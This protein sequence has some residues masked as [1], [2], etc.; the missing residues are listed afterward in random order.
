MREAKHM[1]ERGS[2]WSAHQ[3]R[4]VQTSRGGR[5]AGDTSIWTVAPRPGDMG[6][7][8]RVQRE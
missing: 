2:P 8:K 1:L 5:Q 4:K 7:R 6:G 3:G